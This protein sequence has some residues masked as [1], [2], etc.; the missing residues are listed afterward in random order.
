MRKLAGLLL[1]GL[2]AA[3]ALIS[4]PSAGAT[5]AEPA[6]AQHVRVVRALGEDKLYYRPHFFLLSGDGT[7]GMDKVRWMSWGGAKARGTGRAFVNDCIPYCAA[8]HV[9]RPRAR[10]TLS[11]VVDCEGTPIYV[12]LEYALTGPLPKG[13]PRHGGYSMRPLGADGKPVC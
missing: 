13:F 3:T 11:K 4:A 7:F 8:G 2:V 9:D 1:A 5:N 10:L 6:A 12:R